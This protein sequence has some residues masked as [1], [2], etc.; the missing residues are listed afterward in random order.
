MDYKNNCF[1][2]ISIIINI[3]IL[4]IVYSYAMKLKTNL[5]QFTTLV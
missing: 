3:H 5:T 4:Y 1:Y 2:T